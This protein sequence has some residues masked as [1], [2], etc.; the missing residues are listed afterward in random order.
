MILPQDHAKRFQL[1]DEVHARPPEALSSPCAI[2][3]LA[4]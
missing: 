1:N 3:Y 2:T 4:L